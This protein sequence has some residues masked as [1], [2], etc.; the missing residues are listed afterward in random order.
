MSLN[1]KTIVLT[2]AHGGIG[3]CLL[4]LL[5]TAGANVIA[6]ARQSEADVVGVDLANTEAVEAFADTLKSRDVDILINLA[7]MMY[8]GHFTEQSAS[9][10][11]SMIR[12]NVTTPLLLSQAVI[13]SMLAKGS[14]TIVN[15][16]S[17][18]GA[19]AFPHFATYSCTKAAL[20]SMSEGLR[21]EYQG[22]GIQVT[23][24]APRAVDTPFNHGAIAE[25]HRR[26]N[27]HSDSPEK[28]AEI[29]YTAIEKQLDN[30]NIGMPESLFVRINANFPSLIDKALRSKRDV[31]NNILKEKHR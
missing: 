17:I 18:F 24:I 4:T 31:A 2:G 30:V 10:L 29:I 13:P 19:L 20:K 14:G 5:K 6:V 23:H 8:F 7:G 27:V 9:D 15:I 16:G 1:G 22:R 11:E 25:L 3:H 28:V 26:T 12:V 21:R